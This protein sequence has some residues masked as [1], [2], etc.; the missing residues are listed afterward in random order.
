MEDRRI[1]AAI[2]VV[3]AVVFAI[4]IYFIVTS[5]TTDTP[6]VETAVA[7]VPETPPTP[8]VSPDPVPNFDILRLDTEGVQFSAEGPAVFAGRGTPG[9]T[10]RI[11]VDGKQEAEA[12]A[13]ADGTWAAVADLSV[14]PGQNVLVTLEETTPS[15]EVRKGTNP[16]ILIAGPG[17]PIIAKFASE[18]V[19]ILQAPAPD[20]EAGITL[21]IFSYGAG[22]DP[23][24]AGRG[25]TPGD[26]VS[27]FM[28][29]TSVGEF[30]LLFRTKV[31]ADKQWSGIIKDEVP[32]G[33][34]YTIRAV[35]GSTPTSPGVEVVFLLERADPDNKAHADGSITVQRGN[36]L[37][38]IARKAYGEGIRFHLI[39]SANLAKIED[40][41]LIYPGQ[42]LKLPQAEGQ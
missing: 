20:P 30:K 37:W 12:V 36:S 35:R 4:A 34:S 38:R 23:R 21:D 18:G 29:P 6:P 40:P 41:N 1:L 19:V 31:D 3:A 9:A 14:V 11:F 39:Y 25:T 16:V 42:V 17:G 5:E 7:P 27:V 22:R 33:V 10:V 13:G 32:E 28:R 15:G 24:I 2:G 8:A 26:E